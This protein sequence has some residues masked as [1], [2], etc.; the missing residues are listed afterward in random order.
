[1]GSVW[2]APTAVPETSTSTATAALLAHLKR[3][4]A[5]FTVELANLPEVGGLATLETALWP[6]V[7]CG[8]VTNDTVQP[9]GRLQQQVVA[10]ATAHRTAA[11]AATPKLGGAVAAGGF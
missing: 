6:L 10:A 2:W 7:W 4:G 11:R 8:Q 3:R 9:L 5:C 1:M